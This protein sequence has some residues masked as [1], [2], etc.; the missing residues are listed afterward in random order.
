MTPQQ[1]VKNSFAAPRPDAPAARFR[2]RGGPAPPGEGPPA[3]M[4]A[5]RHV[6]GR[7]AS[8]TGRRGGRAVSGT[9][10][11]ESSSSGHPFPH[12]HDHRTRHP[13]KP[14]IYS[15]C[16]ASVTYSV[17]LRPLLFFCLYGLVFDHYFMLPPP[18]MSTV[19]GKKNQKKPAIRHG[20]DVSADFNLAKNGGFL[21]LNPPA[22]GG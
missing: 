19:Q 6:G 11:E 13:A 14:A 9:K 16:P 8:G 22:T 15:P 17:F 3:W 5:Y 10:A 12:K 18:A 2:R 4:H 20:P 1:Q 21:R 7:A